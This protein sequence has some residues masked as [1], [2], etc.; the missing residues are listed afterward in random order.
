MLALK[1][2][3]AYKF[4]ERLEIYCETTSE[5]LLSDQSGWCKFE[6]SNE[7]IFEEFLIEVIISR[8]VDKTFHRSSKG[9]EQPQKQL[10]WSEATD[11]KVDEE[12]SEEERK[13][14]K[15]IE[16]SQAEVYEDLT[17]DEKTAR[18][19]QS[20]LH[21]QLPRTPLQIRMPQIFISGGQYKSK[22]SYEIPRPQTRTDRNPRSYQRHPTTPM[23]SFTEEEKFYKFPSAREGW[24]C[25]ILPRAQ[26]RST[27]KVPS[28]GQEDISSYSTSWSEPRSP[29]HYMRMDE[30]WA[31]LEKDK[32]DGAE[33]VAFTVVPP[34]YPEL[35]A[36][37]AGQ[38]MLKRSR[39]PVRI[40][41]LPFN[42]HT[43]SSRIPV[44]TMPSRIPRRTERLLKSRA[45][46][47]KIPARIERLRKRGAM[48]S[49]IP[50]RTE[51]L[52]KRYTMPSSVPLRKEYLPK[53]YTMPSRIPIRTK[54][55]LKRGVLLSTK[56]ARTGRLFGAMPSRIPA[57]KELL[58]RRRRV[59]T[60]TFAE[61]P[62][63]IYKAS[64]VT[65]AM[66]SGM[67]TR[68]W[69]TLQEPYQLPRPSKE[70]DLRQAAQRQAVKSMRDLAIE[71]HRAKVSG[72]RTIPNAW[73]AQM[74]ALER[75]RA[76][77]AVKRQAE[78]R[79]RDLEIENQ[80]AKA[81]AKET[82]LSPE[83]AQ[84]AALERIR[85]AGI[86]KVFEIVYG[87]KP[88]VTIDI[89]PSS[90]QADIEPLPSSPQDSSKK[91]PS[92]TKI[93]QDEI[94]QRH[95]CL[96][97]RIDEYNDRVDT[98]D[99]YMERIKDSQEPYVV[100]ERFDEL[101]I[102]EAAASRELEAVRE[103]AN[104]QLQDLMEMRSRSQ[105]T[106][107]RVSV[108]DLN[109]EAPRE[110]EVVREA[111]N[112]QLQ[113]LMEIRSRSQRT[114][115]R[116]SIPD[117]NRLSS[118]ELEAIREA[119]NRQL[120]DLMEMRS[121]SQ[122]TYPR[123]SIP[124]L[125]REAPR[126]FEVVREAANRQLQ[127]LMEIRSRSQRTYP[128]VSIPDL[129][130]LS[131]RELEAIRE[132]AN[133]QL[134]DLMEMRSRSE[135]TYPRV[136]IPDLNRVASTAAPHYNVAELSN[137]G[138]KRTGKLH[139]DRLYSSRLNYEA[140][141]KLSAAERRTWNEARPVGSK[142]RYIS[143]LSQVTEP[144]LS[145]KAPRGTVSSRTSLEGTRHACPIH[146]MR[147]PRPQGTRRSRTLSVEKFPRDF[148]E[149]Y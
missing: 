58:P 54:R 131:S 1:S 88:S 40:K 76:A 42:R 9:P 78:K 52:P 108:P 31:N 71:K 34:T 50:L 140:R 41:N 89:V 17:E 14:F 146:S 24:S 21:H 2:S 10:S 134:Q 70:Y 56:P 120:Q 81:S 44:D 116:V 77:E 119:A 73:E 4:W 132:A 57:R 121:R 83:E 124:D 36:Y 75:I 32:A 86:D 82:V 138:E 87:R 45:M 3:N 61:L 15:I 97:D 30:L 123:I 137:R 114:Y 47:P 130:R 12:F 112:K 46:P 122:R 55:L 113:D 129:N 18:L 126:E 142:I 6:K 20:H 64:P 74:A 49:R 63:R 60:V 147:L 43:T 144:R 65:K 13:C 127:D 7:V 27:I 136:S 19:L 115:P 103:A 72:K 39:L 128:R 66:R 93:I 125:N 118:S 35:K 26:Q 29:V 11:N 48:P 85:S 106:Y 68:R 98:L 67:Q 139:S 101:A 149:Y 80:R 53:S 117:L 145:F 102:R 23:T 69:N 133:R 107:P 22:S 104:R 5:E 100:P 79:M 95:Q 94:Q 96:M 111:A 110:F 90:L 143:H 84:R 38:T 16:E 62:H 28:T 25:L 135:R 33:S 99:H 91:I 92:P 105:R 51:Y 8:L 141:P 37:P 109:R 59:K 148:Q